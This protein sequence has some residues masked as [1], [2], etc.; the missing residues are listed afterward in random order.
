MALE[1]EVELRV[2]VSPEVGVS[3]LAEVMSVEE[4]VGSTVLVAVP[5]LVDEDVKL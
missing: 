2:N 3:R 4:S 5:V 1:L